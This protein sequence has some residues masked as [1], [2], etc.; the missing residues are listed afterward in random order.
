MGALKMAATP[1][2]APQPVSSRRRR[3]P[4]RSTLAAL[5][6]MAAPV[7]EIGRLGARRAPK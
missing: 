5:E 3:R 6:P 2:A 7:T 1:A 4:A